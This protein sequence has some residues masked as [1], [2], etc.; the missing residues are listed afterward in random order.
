V[1]KTMLAQLLE[2]RYPGYNWER[3]YLLN[4]RYAQQKRLERA[5]ISLFAVTAFFFFFYLFV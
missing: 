4:G 1:N 3:M 2:E 5:V